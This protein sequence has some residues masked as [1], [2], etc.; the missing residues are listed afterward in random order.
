M[1]RRLFRREPHDPWGK[2][3]KYAAIINDYHW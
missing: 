2:R 1:L 3:Y